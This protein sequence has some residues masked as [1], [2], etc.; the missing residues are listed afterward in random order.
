MYREGGWTPGHE[1]TVLLHPLWLARNVFR[2]PTSRKRGSASRN[3][4][5]LPAEAASA[6]AEPVALG[7]SAL[8]AAPRLPPG[9]AAAAPSAAAAEAAAGCLAMPALRS[10][11]HAPSGS[12]GSEESVAWKV[13]TS[14]PAVGGEVLCHRAVQDHQGLYACRSTSKHSP[15][16]HHVVRCIMLQRARASRTCQH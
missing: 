2:S 9:S 4:A 5:A 14:T 1:C 7:P 3:A 6:A 10:R 11:A 8:L 13:C 16:Q 15:T 12:A